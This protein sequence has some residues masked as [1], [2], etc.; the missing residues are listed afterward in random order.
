MDLIAYS[1]KQIE[2]VNNYIKKYYGEVPRCRGIR[3]M[4]LE[5]KVETKPNID[6][7]D[8]FEV[9]ENEK[10]DYSEAIN[11]F[12]KYVGQDVIYIHT[13]CGDCGLGY[14]NECSNYISC[15][16]KDWEEKN[17]DLFLEHIT[18]SFDPTYCTHYFKAV[19]NDNYKEILGMISNE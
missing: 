18:D 12:N 13:R 17:K 16:A 8:L 1:N 19:V 15:G 3:F 5:E 2:E 6:V 10:Y 14:D 4:K 11:M 9:E 7:I